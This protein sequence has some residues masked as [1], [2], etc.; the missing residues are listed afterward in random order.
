MAVTHERATVA[1][2]FEI[3]KPVGFGQ[4]RDRFFFVHARHVQS[5]AG[6]ANSDVVLLSLPPGTIGFHLFHLFR[7]AYGANGL[8]SLG[9]GA[10]TDTA[11]QAV[12]ADINTYVD[13]SDASLAG[14]HALTTNAVAAGITTL[15]GVDLTL[16][17]T[18]AAA[19]TLPQNTVHELFIIY[20]VSPIP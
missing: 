1:R 17:F 3:Q 16:T 20:S 9:L 2:S 11:S 14:L 6:D 10:Y 18:T 7:G 4:P 13:A 12:S 8:V 5:A 15:A 19:S